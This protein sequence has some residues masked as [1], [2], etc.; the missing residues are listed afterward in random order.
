MPVGSRRTVT[1]AAVAV[2]VALPALYGA[3]VG[4]LVR[5]NARRLGE[6]DLA[7]QLR[8]YADDVRFVFPGRSSWAGEFRGKKEVE[9]WLRRFVDAGLKIEFDDVLVSGPPWATRLCL[10][11][12]DYCEDEHGETVY[13]NEG[14]I[15]GH[16]RW[17]RLTHYVVFEDTRRGEEFDTYLATVG[18]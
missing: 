16:A 15:Y 6:G 5:H 11:F 9:R 10:R 2:G 8:T 18:K 12:H 1:A 13:A 14:T 3:A 7:P 17:G 4:A